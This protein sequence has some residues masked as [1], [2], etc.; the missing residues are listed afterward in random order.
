MGET[1]ENIHQDQIATQREGYQQPVN[2]AS[3]KDY[4]WGSTMP[5]S[6]LFALKSDTSP[7]G[8]P[9]HSTA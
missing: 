8:L 9:Q 3:S 4:S 1:A 5:R 2:L 6:G 7:E